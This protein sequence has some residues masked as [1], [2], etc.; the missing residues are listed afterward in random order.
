MAMK[1]FAWRAIIKWQ[2]KNSRPVSDV[3]AMDAEKRISTV[4]YIF[5]ELEASLK[6]VLHNKERESVITEGLANAFTFYKDNYA[7]R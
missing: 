1:G 6:A 5:D 7:Y 3:A 4:K 2:K